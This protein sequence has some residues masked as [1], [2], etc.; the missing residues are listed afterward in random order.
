[1]IKRAN[2]RVHNLDCPQCAEGLKKELSSI[3]NISFIEIRH[4]QATIAFNFTKAN[5]ISTVENQLT[6]LGY[7]PFGDKISSKKQFECYCDNA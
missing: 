4:T 2:I 7:P 5:D 6:Y 3:K 1:M